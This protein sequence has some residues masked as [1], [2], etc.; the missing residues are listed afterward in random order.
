LAVADVALLAVQDPGAVGLLH[1][2]RLDVVRVGARV[3][4]GEREPG[5]LAARGEVGEEALLLLVAPEHEDALEPDRLVHAHDDRK[6]RVDL[7]ERL[8]NARVAGLREALAAVLLGNV[9]AAQPALA[10]LADRLVA[11]PALLLDLAAVVALAELAQRVDEPA[12]AVL[13]ARLGL[14][15]REHELLVDLAEE[16]RLCERGDRLRLGDLR[17]GL[18]RGLHLAQLMP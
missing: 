2:A 3:R 7:R 15:P 1:R 6:R 12:D 18:G 11:D 10:D 5:E 17:L 14:R 13:L 8:E 4:L 16:E 9:E